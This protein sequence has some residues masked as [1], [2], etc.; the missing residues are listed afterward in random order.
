MLIVQA[1]TPAVLMQL[2]LQSPLYVAWARTGLMSSETGMA[3]ASP[4]PVLLTVIW[5]VSLSPGFAVL[6]GANVPSL[7]LTS[8]T[9]LMSGVLTVVFVSQSGSSLAAG[10]LEPGPV[11]TTTFGSSVVPSGNTSSSVTEKVRTTWPPDGTSIVQSSTPAV[12][13]QLLLQSPLY[14]AWAR[15]GLMSSLTGMSLASESPVLLTVIWK[16]RVSPG[17]AV[18]VGAKAPSLVLKSFRTLMSGAAST[19]VSVSQSG[20]SLSAA[21][22]EPGPVTTTTFGRWVVPSGNV[23]LS[24]TE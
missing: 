3:L 19:V 8:F 16:V 13:L 17:S 11:T 4:S 20:S 7:V 1:S 18:P 2:L 9:T 22:L 21:Q 23:S 5:K 24:V 12:L 14:V 15:T 10:Q 6:V